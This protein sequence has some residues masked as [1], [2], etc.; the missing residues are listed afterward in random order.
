MSNKSNIDQ[1]TLSILLS[2]L[3]NVHDSIRA[4]DTKAQIVS[5]GFI[6]S[7]GFITT[8]G[9]MAPGNPQFSISLVVFSWL[10]GVVPVMMFAYVLY[11]SR[12]M[13]PKLGAGNG[14]LQR[15]YYLLDERYSNLDEYIEAIDR[16]DWKIE[17]VY[18][19][20]KNSLLRDLK[21]KR[22]VRA[23]SFAG[24][25]FAFIFLTQ[26]LRSLEILPR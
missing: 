5:L 17:L 8:V 10:P 22:F 13:A 14:N 2:S 1:A 15:S 18:E 12:S 16:S 6:F 23:L 19:I 25:S 3:H 24:V 26:A 4:Y 11:P 9:A 20:Q 21:R 7:L